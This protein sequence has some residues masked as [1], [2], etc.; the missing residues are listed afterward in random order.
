MHLISQSKYKTE[1]KNYTG[2]QTIETRRDIAAA[3]A[4]MHNSKQARRN[5][6]GQWGFIPYSVVSIK[7]TGSLN[8]FEVFVPP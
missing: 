3:V 6:W 7:R 5:I 8:Y 1:Q 4:E 2:H